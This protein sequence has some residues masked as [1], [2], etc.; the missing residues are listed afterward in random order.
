VGAQHLIGVSAK[1][2]T[3]SVI[4]DALTKGSTIR[5]MTLCEPETLPP[6]LKSFGSISLSLEIRGRRDVVVLFDEKPPA[7]LEVVPDAAV[8]QLEGST[9]L[10]AIGEVV[11]RFYRARAF[12]DVRNTQLESAKCLRQFS[13]TCA[14]PTSAHAQLGTLL[15]L[16]S[17]WAIQHKPKVN[18]KSLWRPSVWSDQITDRQDENTSADIVLHEP[19]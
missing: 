8:W 9:Q 14:P 4:R 7:G 13:L 3:K 1:G 19:G 5:L 16:K 18:A 2:F 12:A 15:F 17:E 6:F 11:E 10:I